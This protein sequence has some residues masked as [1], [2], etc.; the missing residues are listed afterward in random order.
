MVMDNAH[1]GIFAPV[2]RLIVPQMGGNASIWHLNDCSADH[3]FVR[4]FLCPGQLQPRADQFKAITF[5]IPF[6]DT[7][8]MGNVVGLRFQANGIGRH[9]HTP[10]KN[11]RIML[12]LFPIHS[13]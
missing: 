8:E 4:R 2:F 11:F 7:E 1:N 9:Q 10:F 12:V 13:I 3:T 5:C 6:N